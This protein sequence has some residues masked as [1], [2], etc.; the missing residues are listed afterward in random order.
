MKTN[1]KANG[2]EFVINNETMF[3]HVDHIFSDLHITK[4]RIDEFCDEHR[5]EAYGQIS[6]YAKGIVDMIKH[7]EETKHD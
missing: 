7:L 5:T 3:I 1:Y 4:A 6:K 2:V